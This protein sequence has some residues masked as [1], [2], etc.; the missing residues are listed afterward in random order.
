VLWTILSIALSLSVLLGLFAVAAVYRAGQVERA[1][2]ARRCGGVNTL[3]RLRETAPG[4]PICNTGA[5]PLEESQFEVT[6]GLLSVPSS[7]K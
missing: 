4:T 5:A 2:E 1:L 3:G 6:D 7:S